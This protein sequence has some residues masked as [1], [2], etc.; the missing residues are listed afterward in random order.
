MREDFKSLQYRHFMLYF[1]FNLSQLWGDRCKPPAKHLLYGIWTHD[2]LH[3]GHWSCS[4]QTQGVGFYRETHNTK[5]IRWQRFN[6]ASKQYSEK[7]KRAKLLRGICDPPALTNHQK[8]PRKHTQ[9]TPG[10]RRAL[11][12]RADTHT[13][14]HTHDPLLECIWNETKRK[15][16]WRE[17]E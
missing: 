6:S 1:S 9:T 11:Y 12:A 16:G 4:G 8:Y 17:G 7:E 5:R 13:H 3:A 10:M 2:V 15:R 14:T